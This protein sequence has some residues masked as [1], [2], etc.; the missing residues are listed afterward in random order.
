[1]LRR[2]R[3]TPSSCILIQTPWTSTQCR[4]A[5]GVFHRTPDTS[6]AMDRFLHI[7]HYTAWMTVIRNN[8]RCQAQQTRPACHC[9]A[10]HLA[11][12][13][14]LSQSHC[15]SEVSRRYS[16]TVMLHNDI[17]TPANNKKL[18]CRR[19]TAR[20]FVSSLS[21]SRSLEVSGDKQR[22]ALNPCNANVS[23]HASR[24]RCCPLLSMLIHYNNNC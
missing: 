21:E 7:R 5:T 13:A 11:N 19:E 12:L 2:S 8:Y 4:P 10:C 6:Q 18:S 14:A 15:H 24:V 23:M 1:M 20:C 3:G 17:V 16:Y 9:R 22:N